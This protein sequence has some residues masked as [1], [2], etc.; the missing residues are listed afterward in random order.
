M[1]IENAI[2]KALLKYSEQ[3]E[4]FRNWVIKNSLKTTMRYLIQLVF[5]AFLILAFLTHLIYWISGRSAFTE[6]FALAT[7]LVIPILMMI[8]GIYVVLIFLTWEEGL[9]DDDGEESEKK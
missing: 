5:G 1:N 8:G 4:R 6:S 2:K 3:Y 7:I 9:K